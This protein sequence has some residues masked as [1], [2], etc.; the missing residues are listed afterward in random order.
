[1]S[2]YR[3]WIDCIIDMSVKFNNNQKKVERACKGRAKKKSTDPNDYYKD[4]LFEEG[5]CVNEE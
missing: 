1:M 3:D 5:D 4:G 2:Y